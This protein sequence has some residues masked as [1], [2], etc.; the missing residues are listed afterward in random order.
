MARLGAPAAFCFLLFAILGVLLGCASGES[1]EGELPDLGT[2]G[3]RI[4]RDAGRIALDA[5]LASAEARERFATLY[6]A[7]HHRA[8]TDELL[9]DLAAEPALAPMAE[10]VRASLQAELEADDGDT[11]RVRESWSDALV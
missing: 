3:Q 8:S 11:R 2:S 9:Q 6:P 4:E 10:G 7:L 1:A 5:F